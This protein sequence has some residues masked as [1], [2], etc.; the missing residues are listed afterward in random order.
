MARSVCLLAL[1]L[2][3]SHM[4]GQWVPAGVPFRITE[5]G[6]IH[7]DTIADALYFCGESSLDNDFQFDDGAVPVYTNGQWDTLGVFG[8]RVQTMAR[9]NDTLIA[10]GPF[11]GWNGDLSVQHFAY[12]NGMAWLPFGDFG[13]SWAYRLK[14]IDGEL[15]AIGAFDVVDGQSCQGIAKRVGGHWEPVGVFNT[16]SPPYIQDLVEWNGTLY[17]TGVISYSAQGPNH[18]AYLSN[19][20]WLPVAPGILSGFGAG[21][22]LAVYNDELYVSG[23]IPIAAGNAG[24]G[25]MRWDGQA[26]H[27][28]GTGFQG[29][30]GAYL[31][32]VGASELEVYD[33]KLWACGTFSYA[34]GV[35]CPGIAYW[36]GV[37]WCGLP[38]GPE[39]EINTIEF[40]HDT[41]FASCHVNL[42]GEPVNCAVK[43]IGSVYSDTC[44]VA[45]GLGAQLTLPRSALRACR[46]G[47]GMVEVVGVPG[48]E[49][50][51]MLLDVAGRIVWGRQVRSV[52]GEPLQLPLPAVPGGVHLLRIGNVGTVR[53]LGP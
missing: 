49:H 22:A 45:V 16:A 19:G 41:L 12:W 2:C 48:G 38:L 10:A 32:L 35:P 46:R 51:V 53:F 37:R 14:T 25:I 40:F 26:F 52:G 27:P 34:G 13:G 36:D 44:S 18:I 21:R 6:N 8:G 20:E 39:P 9:W 33:N 3:A 29:I 17:A 5:M 31:Y 47:N 4:Q 15:Y 50:E 11:A 1:L 24:H 42:N 43:F 28:V 23:S 7:K 30:D